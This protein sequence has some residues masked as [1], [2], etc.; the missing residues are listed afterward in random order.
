MKL[1]PRWSAIDKYDSYCCIQYF[2]KLFDRHCI[3]QTEE[4]EE[5]EEEEAIGWDDRPRPTV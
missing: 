5:E 4:G 3:G 2:V 1:I